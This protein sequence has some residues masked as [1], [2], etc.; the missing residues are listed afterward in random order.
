MLEVP[1]LP[2]LIQ[3]QMMK[4]LESDYWFLPIL[5]NQGTS[6]VDNLSVLF[7]VEVFQLILVLVSSTNKTD[8][9]DI[10]VTEILLKVALNIITQAKPI[11]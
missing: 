1:L 7:Q 8:S 5:P 10:P 11:V 4:V 9:H 6:S 3:W 2:W